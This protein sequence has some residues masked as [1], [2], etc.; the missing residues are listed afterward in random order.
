[1][2]LLKLPRDVRDGRWRSEMMLRLPSIL[3]CKLHLHKLRLFKANHVK[4]AKATRSRTGIKI[5][6]DFSCLK[7]YMILL[8]H[9]H[10]IS[11]FESHYNEVFYLTLQQSILQEDG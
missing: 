3:N 7:D 9:K 8:S 1:M 11:S 10:I 2:P 4:M 5:F 6:V